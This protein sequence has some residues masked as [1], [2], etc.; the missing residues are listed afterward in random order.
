VSFLKDPIKILAAMLRFR[1]DGVI[2]SMRVN[3][4]K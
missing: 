3:K 2:H 4:S 1:F